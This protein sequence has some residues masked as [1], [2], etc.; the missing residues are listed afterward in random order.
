MREPARS[1]SVAV[2][3]VNYNAGSL[4]ERCLSSLDT[5]TLSPRRV[6]VVDNASAD[7]S[8]DGIDVRR[9]GVE[10]IRCERNHGFAR[11]NNIGIEA[12]A[13]CDWIACLNPDAFPEPEWLERFMQATD[14][15]VEYDFFGCKLLQAEKPERLDGTGDVYHASGLAWRRDHGRLE[16]EGVNEDDE[17]FAPCAAAALYRRAALVEVGGFDESFFCYFED[18]D[19]AFRLRLKGHRCIYVAAARVRHMGSAITGRRSEFSVYHGHRNLVWTYVKNMPPLLFWLYLPLHLAV[20]VGSLLF[21]SLKGQA[22]PIF[23]AKFDAVRGLRRVWAERRKVQAHRRVTA[24]AVN[25]LM[26]KSLAAVFN[27]A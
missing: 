1:S 22:R 20:N 19:L 13:D 23:R 18:I 27:R 3:I 4:L 16:R 9:P 17:I 2:V 26:V 15:H 6:I 14:A 11:A 7:G 10:V 21:F 8:A 5:Q 25:R 24:A 12:A